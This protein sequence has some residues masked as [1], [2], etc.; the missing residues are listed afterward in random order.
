M[1]DG[2]ERALHVVRQEEHRIE[3]HDETHTNEHPAL[4]MAQIRVDVEIRYQR[5]VQRVLLRTL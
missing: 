3:E 5:L 4:G 1:P 2:V